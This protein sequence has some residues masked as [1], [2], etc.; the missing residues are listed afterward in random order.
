M[1][2]SK[3][4]EYGL[5]AALHLAAEQPSSYLAIRD[6]SRALGIPYPFLAKIAQD[7]IAAGVL[8][9]QRGP[10]GGV[11]LAR[12]ASRITLEEIVVAIDGPGIFTECVLGLPGCGVQRPC[13]LHAQWAGTR[14]RIRAM[15]AAASLAEVAERVQTDGLRLADLTAQASE[16]A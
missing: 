8:T 3:R 15:F 12:P 5:R 11:A 10:T 7:L 6:I 4:C 1:L 9:S 13:P 14:E 16:G 2:L